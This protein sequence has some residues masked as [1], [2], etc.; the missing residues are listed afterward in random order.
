MA[1]YK[2]RKNIKKILRKSPNII[3]NFV[4]DLINPIRKTF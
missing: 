2:S 1:S 4:I 3:S